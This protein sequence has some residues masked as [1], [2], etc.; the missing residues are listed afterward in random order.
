MRLLEDGSNATVVAALQQLHDFAP[1]Y[2][3]VQKPDLASGIRHVI[4]KVDEGNAFVGSGYLL[5]V[6][7]FTPWYGTGKVLQ[8]ELVLR[9]PSQRRYSLRDVAYF[10]ESLGEVRRCDMVLAGNSYTSIGMSRLYQSRQHGFKKCSEIFYK[11]L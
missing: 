10:I 1:F 3:W 11:E 4:D 5:L 8:E 6:G 9:L 7:E 2:G